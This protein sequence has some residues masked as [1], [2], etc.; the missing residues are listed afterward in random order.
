VVE[1]GGSRLNACISMQFTFCLGSSSLW[2]LLDRVLIEKGSPPPRRILSTTPFSNALCSFNVV[3]PPIPGPPAP[4]P[5]SEGI[6][7]PGAGW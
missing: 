6:L 5:R 3:K 2:S 4:T 7:V 1:G